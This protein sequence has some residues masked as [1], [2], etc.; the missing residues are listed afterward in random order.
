MSEPFR[1]PIVTGPWS[2]GGQDCGGSWGTLQGGGG[3]WERSCWVHKVLCL[4]PFMAAREQEE[5]PGA[6]TPLSLPSYPL[7][8]AA[9]PEGVGKES[10]WCVWHQSRSVHENPARTQPCSSFFPSLMGQS[11]VAAKRQLVELGYP[12]PASAPPPPGS[13]RYP[14]SH[15]RCAWNA[16]VYPA[17]SSRVGEPGCLSRL[18][19]RLAG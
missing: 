6:P 12:A 17:Q 15:T 4:L 10:E 5:E 18:C 19:C 1:T 13:A 9:C 8:Q 7:S 2:P 11:W 14:T 16:Q 3:E